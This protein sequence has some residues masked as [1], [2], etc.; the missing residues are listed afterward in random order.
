M[1]KDI[2]IE[3]L[4]SGMVLANAVKSKHGQ[5]I[6]K[7][8]TVLNH[9]LI[10]RIKFCKIEEVS[11]D[12]PTPIQD[13]DVMVS[14]LDVDSAPVVEPMEAPVPEVSV[15]VEE[16]P[17][18]TPPVEAPHEKTT[19]EEIVSYNQK[20]LNT[21]EYQSFQLEYTKT[22][23]KM[24]TIF[25]KIKDGDN[26]LPTDELL[27]DCS[28]LFL[29][30]T[31][32]ELFSMIFNMRS[33]DDSV[34]AHSL[35]VALISRT[36]G[37]WLKFSKSDLDTLT[38]AGLLHDI[39]KLTIPD[40]VLNKTG[41]L[42]DEEFEMIRQHPLE[43]TRMLRRINADSRICAAALQHHERFD[44]SGYPRRLSEDEI[45]DFAAIIAIADVYDAMTAARA[46]RSARCAF[47]VIH[48]FEQDGLHKYKTKYILTFLERIANL[49]QNSQ[50]ILNDGRHAKVVYINKGALSRPIVELADHTMLDLSHERDFFISAIV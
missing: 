41:K 40:E 33:I 8:G 14:A 7:A 31:S 47:Q 29:S 36:I 6:A 45:D 2:K 30:K 24:K 22:L 25:L 26:N 21:S 44:G 15:P 34:Y 37:R 19:V 48:E 20:L 32:L 12:E 5:T 49:Y 28:H 46:Y 38:M 27:R 35:N 4:K 3:D 23:E 43:G 17:K 18:E 9:A 10:S 1:R 16:P 50:V 13:I 39:G 11:I 42:T